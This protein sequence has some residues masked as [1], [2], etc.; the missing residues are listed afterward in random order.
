MLRGLLSDWKQPLSYI[1]TSGPIKAVNLE[2]AVKEILENLIDIG[3]DVRAVVCDQEDKE[4]IKTALKLTLR[5]IYVTPWSKMKVKLATQVFS[6][7]VYAS[8]MTAIDINEMSSDGKGT[9][10]FVK[11]MNDLFDNLNSRA[12]YDRNPQC[13]PLSEKN[14][15]IEKNLLEAMTLLN[16]L[17]VRNNGKKN[18]PCIDGFILSIQSILSLWYDLRDEGINFLLTSRLNQDPLENL[19]AVLRQRS[20]NNLN[21]TAQQLRQN[22]QTVVNMKLLS[23][24]L[25]ANCERDSDTSLLSSEDFSNTEIDDVSKATITSFI[26]VQDNH[27]DDEPLKDLNEKSLEV[28]DDYDSEAEPDSEDDEISTENNGFSL[29]CSGRSTHPSWKV[30]EMCLTRRESPGVQRGTLSAALVPENMLRTSERPAG[31]AP[32]SLVTVSLYAKPSCREL[33]SSIARTISKVARASPSVRGQ[34]TKT[35]L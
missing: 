35:K 23:P 34:T 3:F 8:L 27:E 9:A 30:D 31:S 5:H 29:A 25:S 4:G 15:D 22:M 24:P 7:S 13:R 33:P 14:P 26:N 10:N 17:K 32:L 1:L 2:D 6:H 18:P 12:P 11:F 28:I 21:P 16:N 20:G 19:F